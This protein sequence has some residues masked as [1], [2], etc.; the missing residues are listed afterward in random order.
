MLSFQFHALI[1][2][3]RMRPTSFVCLL[4]S[5]SLRFES[6]EPFDSSAVTRFWM[7]CLWR[8]ISF[9]VKPLELEKTKEG[10]TTFEN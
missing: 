3:L 1:V 2:Y 6:S 5:A 4:D 8:W 10:K 9:V 7:Y